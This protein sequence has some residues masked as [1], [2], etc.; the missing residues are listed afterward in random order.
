MQEGEAKRIVVR[1]RDLSRSV[2]PTS[3]EDAASS[4]LRLQGCTPQQGRRKESHLVEKGGER[5]RVVRR[6]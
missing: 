2:A 1:I 6:L 5:L 3:P 4:N